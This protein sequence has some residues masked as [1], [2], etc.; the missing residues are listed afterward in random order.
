MVKQIKVCFQTYGCSYNQQDTEIMK[1]IILKDNL[2]KIVDSFDDCDVIIVNG[3]IVKDPTE[4]KIRHF[5]NSAIAKNKKVVLAG[6]FGQVHSE[7][8]TEY[9]LI[10]TNSVDKIIEAINS[11][12]VGN[13]EHFIVNTK[14]DKVK[15]MNELANNSY[16][17]TI[18]IIPIAEGC[19]GSCTYCATRF[20]RSSLKS[21]KPNDVLKTIKLALDEGVKEFWL[22]AQD[23]GCYGHDIDTNIIDLLKLILSKLNKHSFFIRL[24]MMNPNYAKEYLNE[25][26]QI[27]KDN[28][29]FKFI[30]LP[31]QSCSDNVLSVMKRKYKANDFSIVVNTLRREI[32]NI[33]IMTDIIVGFPGETQ[34]DFNQTLKCIKDLKPEIM[35]ISRFWAKSG[36]PAFSM[37]QV[38]KEKSM[39]R[40]KKLYDFYRSYIKEK[41]ERF[42]NDSFDVYFD[43]LGKESG[44]YIGRN[45]YY[46]LI[47]VKSDT[48]L[49]GT[50]RQVVVKRVY[51]YYLLCDL[52]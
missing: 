10:G 12:I 16:K 22:T 52:A 24:G 44:E 14:L 5:V 3:C 41:Q 32:T 19:L 15:L 51:S 43:E 38:P 25:L 21:A 9:T 20:A 30:H 37:T 2:F 26:V 13:N 49:L 45:S 42:L 28:H 31:V 50:I 33:T 48:N 36:T 46:G 18:Q 29:M 1:L 4:N 11:A 7:T 17:K 6:C 35:N 27:F 39:E 23:T 34:I 8:F 47:V 40:S